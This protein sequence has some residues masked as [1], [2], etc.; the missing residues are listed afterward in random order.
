MAERTDREL[1]SCYTD[2]LVKRSKEGDPDKTFVSHCSSAAYRALYDL[3]KRDAALESP[4]EV[5]AKCAKCGR[6]ETIHVPRL[7]RCRRC[8]GAAV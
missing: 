2:A 6:L 4:S 3:G 1:H 5:P 7:V 8:N